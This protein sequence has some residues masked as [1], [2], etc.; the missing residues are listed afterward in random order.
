MLNI[1]FVNNHGGGFSRTIP[2]DEGTT[3]GEFLQYNIQGFRSEDYR[4]RLNSDMVARHDTELNDGD[5][6]LVT[7]VKT[8]GNQK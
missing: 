8:V 5:Q 6:V 1:E 4:I 2:C 7:P 3:L